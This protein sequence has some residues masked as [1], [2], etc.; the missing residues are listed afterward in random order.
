MAQDHE[1]FMRMALEEAEKG[2]A[3]GNSAVGSVIVRDGTVIARGRNLVS[4]THDPT[5]HAE[6]VALREAGAALRTDTFPGSTLYTT[7]QP[8]PMC[9]GAI[10]FSLVS[11]LVIGGRPD[12]ALRRYGNY[13]AEKLVEMAEWGD[14]LQV[15]PE[16]ILEQECYRVRN[17]W[18]AKNAAKR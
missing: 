18:E 17:D 16:G 1:R 7:M 13:T 8:C 6:T 5:A 4:A 2:G 11:T 15:V 9:C 10:M 14:R 3:E 12:P